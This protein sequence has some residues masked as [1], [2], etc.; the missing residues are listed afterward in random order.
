M[1]GV[2]HHW[3]SVDGYTLVQ[4]VDRYWCWRQREGK[5]D[6]RR[7]GFCRVTECGRGVVRRA[8]LVAALLNTPA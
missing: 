5:K 6:E 7:G 8:A 4:I 1:A 3:R 2:A